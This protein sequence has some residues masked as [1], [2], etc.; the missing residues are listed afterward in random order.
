MN[1]SYGKKHSEYKRWKIYFNGETYYA[2]LPETSPMFMDTPEWEDDS[3]TALKEF[4]NNYE[5]D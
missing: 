4:I 1:H 2:F 5:W 3:L